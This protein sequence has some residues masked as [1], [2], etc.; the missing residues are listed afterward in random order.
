[1]VR[2]HLDKQIDV[3]VAPKLINDPLTNDDELETPLSDCYDDVTIIRKVKPSE[4]SVPATAPMRP[5][6][7]LPQS[8]QKYV[9]KNMPNRPAHKFQWSSAQIV[10]AQ[11]DII[12]N[13]G[14]EFCIE[15]EKAKNSSLASNYN[16]PNITAKGKAFVPLLRLST[17]IAEDF[18]MSDFINSPSTLPVPK[19]KLCTSRAIHSQVESTSKFSSPPSPSGTLP[20]ILLEAKKQKSDYLKSPLVSR[21]SFNSSRENSSISRSIESEMKQRSEFAQKVLATDKTLNISSREINMIASFVG[22]KVAIQNKSYNPG[23]SFSKR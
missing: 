12:E 23:T 2:N 15:G 6:S 7:A 4:S 19:G 11:R 17:L 22:K 16:L 5:I 1:M 3:T 13:N 14:H 21:R 10:Q 20:R 9:K 8:N 18:N